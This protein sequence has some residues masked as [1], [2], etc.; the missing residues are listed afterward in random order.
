MLKATNLLIS[1]F[2][3]AIR[4]KSEVKPELNNHTEWY[5]KVEQLKRNSNHTPKVTIVAAW[6]RDDTG[7][8]A[9]IA[10]DNHPEKGNWADLVK[11]AKRK[12]KTMSCEDFVLQ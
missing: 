1:E 12:D 3:V 6:I 8:G 10:S 5:D 9:V 7:V 11:H 4:P 2:N